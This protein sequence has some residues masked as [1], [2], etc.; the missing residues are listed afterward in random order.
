MFKGLDLL[1]TGF[2]GYGPEFLWGFVSSAVSGFLVIWGLLT[3]LRGHDFKIFMIYR[4]AVAA[5][6]L[7]V[8]TGDPP[9]GRSLRD[10]RGPG[11]GTTEAVR[12]RTPASPR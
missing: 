7:G 1:N 9:S 6:V 12:A 3:Y 10:G 8:I 4:L 5:L 11:G 2:Q